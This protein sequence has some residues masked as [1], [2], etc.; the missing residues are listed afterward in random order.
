MNR[1]LTCALLACAALPSAWAQTYV[2]AE[3]IPSQD[4][5]GT[6]NLTKIL[7][8]GYPN[9]ELWSQR[10]L[11]DCQV[12]QNV[13]NVLSDNRAIT[14]VTFG[15]TRYK[16]AAG[17][18][19]AVT[20]PTYVLTF[21]DSSPAAASA[22]DIFVLD[23]ALGYALNQGG[24]AQFSLPF[25]TKNPFVFALDYAVVT[26]GGFLSGVQAQQFFNHVGT[27]DPELWSGTDAGFTQVNLSNN[28]VNNYLLDDSMLFLIGAVPKQEFIQGLYAATTTTPN[29]GYSPLAKN[30]NPAT[31]KAGAAFPG[32]DWIAFPNG[33]GYLTN[34]PNASPELLS[35]LAAVRQQHLQ[36][37]SNLLNA[38]DKGNVAIYL[39]N[40]FKCPR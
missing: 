14:T 29:A 21:D 36:A 13:I 24:T 20:D 22:S 34:I 35:A 40:Q 11:N 5:V 19:E 31:A 30:G 17:G 27:I 10:L 18:F 12:V 32:N 25:S 37:V 39:N 9:L 23:N 2:S 1:L 28:P 6:A 33:D 26:F 4:I 7:N 3:P 8:L 16:V 15:N 38:I